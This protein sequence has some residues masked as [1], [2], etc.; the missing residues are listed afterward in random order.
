M[1][2]SGGPGCMRMMPDAG[3]GPGAGFMA[4]AP[5]GMGAVGMSHKVGMSN[6][7]YVMQPPVLGPNQSLGPGIHDVEAERW[8]LFVG[9][10]PKAADEYDLWNIFSP[11]G[12][13]LELKILRKK[14]QSCGCGFVTY[15][16]QDLAEEAIR[17]VEWPV[18]SHGP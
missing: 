4:G 10:I 7:Q 16:S 2:M 17:K 15:A 11:I 5:N 12:K 3:I 14:G 6:G 8:K 13:L 9:Q 18:P 1:D